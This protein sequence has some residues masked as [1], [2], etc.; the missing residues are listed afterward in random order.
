MGVK[1]ALIRTSEK[2]FFKH[3]LVFTKPLHKLDKMELEVTALLLYHFFE[4]KKEM[5]NDHL[6]WKLTFDYETKAKIVKEL[7]TN[8]QSFR[9]VLTA[10]RKNNVIVDNQ[11]NPS[12]IPRLDLDR[13]RVFSLVF[14][15]EIN[16]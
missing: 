9:N 12:F 2:N 5:S 14:K 16:D 11:I 4:F 13:S 7:N 1:Q 3:W 6:A 15:F 8:D 10:L